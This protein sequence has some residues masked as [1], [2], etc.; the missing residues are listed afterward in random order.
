MCLV[1]VV[2]CTSLCSVN[3]CSHLCEH[4]ARVL[5]SVLLRLCGNAVAVSFQRSHARNAG[6]LAL[7]AT[8]QY[9]SASEIAH[10]VFPG[11]VAVTLDADVAVKTQAMALCRTLLDR[12][13][14]VRGRQSA[15]S[16]KPIGVPFTQT[17]ACTWVVVVPVARYDAILPLLTV[18]GD[19][20]GPLMKT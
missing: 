11:V 10:K 13:D 7:G 16:L 12:L 6:L 18:W 19:R 1:F 2:V 14:K 4:N 3:T 9:F 15:T 17:S 5:F 8:Q 20:R